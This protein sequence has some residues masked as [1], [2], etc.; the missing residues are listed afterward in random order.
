MNIPLRTLNPFLTVDYVKDGEIATIIQPPYIVTA[1]QSRYKKEQTVIPI[2]LKRD[3]QTYRLTLNVSSNDRLV[4]AFG[5]NGDMWVGKNVLLQKRSLD[6][7]GKQKDVIFVSTVDA[8]E[9]S[10]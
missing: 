7:E 4:K 1:E 6:F 9:D 8:I 2:K 10:L 3:N 5:H